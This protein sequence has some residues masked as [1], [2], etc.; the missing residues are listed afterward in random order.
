[1]FVGIVPE[2]SLIK[3]NAEWKNRV[4][5]VKTT[6][7]SPDIFWFIQSKFQDIV[8]YQTKG[9][10]SSFYTGGKVLVPSERSVASLT[11]EV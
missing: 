4:F 9:S 6:S 3:S 7:K 11:L 2:S 8:H 10:S 1:M 5:I